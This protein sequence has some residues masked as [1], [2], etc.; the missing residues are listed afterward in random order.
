[1]LIAIAAGVVAAFHVGKLPAALPA[2]RAEL[3]L[4]L[5]AAGWVAATFNTIGTLLAMPL[6]VLSIRVTRTGLAIGGLALLAAGGLVGAAAAGAAAL[7][8]S[9]ALEGAGFLAVAVA[10]PALI[11]G[12][13]RTVDRGLAL[14]LWSTYMPIGVALMLALS[15]ALLATAGWRGLWLVNVAVALALLTLLLRSR[16]SYRSAAGTRAVSLEGASRTLVHGGLW[17]LCIAFG[18]YTAQW[19]TIMTWLPTYLVNAAW[20][21][22]GAALATALVVACNVPGNLAGTWVLRRGVRFGTVIA[23]AFVVMGACGP[24]VF[25]ESQPTALRVAACVGFS[26]FGGMLP[27]AVLSGAPRFAERPDHIAM[28]SGVVM[29]GSNLGQFVGPPLVAWQV[30]RAGAWSAATPFLVSCALAGLATAV[31]LSRSRRLAAEHNR[32]PRAR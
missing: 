25:A 30:E 14:G 12:A 20:P 11:V 17:L 22:P 7:L 18:L 21:L 1:V 31:V 27:A 26:F 9:R 32:E 10:V 13:A 5:L 3:G 16:A 6:G 24:L 4:S 29:Q 19:V 2:M 8:A 23:I 15:P 28:T